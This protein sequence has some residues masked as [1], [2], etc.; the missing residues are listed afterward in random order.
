MQP[1]CLLARYL[2]NPLLQRHESIVTG[3]ESSGNPS[4]S[5]EVSKC[6][7]DYLCH[8]T[9]AQALGADNFV[10]A[11]ILLIR[12]ARKSAKKPMNK[13]HM[14]LAGTLEGERGNHR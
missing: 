13:Y 5:L 14:E 4:N 3:C 11:P 12:R 9:N 2:P 7:L 6:A 8:G 1:H 10:S